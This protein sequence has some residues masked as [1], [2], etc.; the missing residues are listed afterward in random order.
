ME[1]A[2]RGRDLGKSSAAL[3]RSCC[4]GREALVL[5][6]STECYKFLEKVGQGTYG[7]VWRCKEKFTGEMVALKR[8]TQQRDHRNGVSVTALREV[9]LLNRYKH[10]NIVGLKEVVTSLHRDQD[11]KSLGAIYMVFSTSRTIYRITGSQV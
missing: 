7:E 9:R 11:A 8:M 4:D 5:S 10:K 2:A 3:E 6:R 1:Y